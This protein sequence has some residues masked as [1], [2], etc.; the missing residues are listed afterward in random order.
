MH[1]GDSGSDDIEIWDRDA[2]RD[3]APGQAGHVNTTSPVSRS[4]ANLAFHD[5]STSALLTLSY[6]AGNGRFP[7]LCGLHIVTCYKSQSSSPALRQKF[8]Q[9][10]ES[11]H[12]KQ[13]AAAS[14]ET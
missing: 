5:L 3:S 11:N 13:G 2:R 8:W 6:L 4:I 7:S 1:D 12:T 9:P 10:R 14:V